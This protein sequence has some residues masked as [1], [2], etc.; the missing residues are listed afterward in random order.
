MH[1]CFQEDYAG[2]FEVKGYK[3]YNIPNVLS[4]RVDDDFHKRRKNVILFFQ[5]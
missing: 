1:S 4:A 3:F 5:N 2:K